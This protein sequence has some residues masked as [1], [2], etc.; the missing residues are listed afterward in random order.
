MIGKRN[1]GKAVV[2]GLLLSTGMYGA[3]W[4]AE[5][6]TSEFLSGKYANGNAIEGVIIDTDKISVN[7][8]IT[9]NG[10]TT[11]A[12]QNQNFIANKEISVDKN[13]DLT[14]NN[15]FLNGPKITGQG[16][17]VVNTTAASGGNPIFVGG[18][19]QANSLTLNTS[20][21]DGIYLYEHDL[22]LDVERLTINATANGFIQET[23][24]PL[25]ILTTP[26]TTTIDDTRSINVNSSGSWAF[27]NNSQAGV[28][29]NV[30]MRS[31]KENS[32]INLMGA[33]GYSHTSAG[34]SI[35]K[36][37]NCQAKCNFLE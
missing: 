18:N 8:S 19:I 26:T 3:V 36:A 22:T 25:A 31:D 11:P 14:F 37:A 24:E 29:N 34:E 9:V 30:Y 15:L 13:V 20:K 21:G 16:N 23:S 27:H 28:L 1:L 10:V 5:V 17:I 12:D 35:L 33:N 32:V 7:Q 2:L 6:T 4:A